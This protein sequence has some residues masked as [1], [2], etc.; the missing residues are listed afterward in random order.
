MDEN[1]ASSEEAAVYFPD[2]NQYRESG[3]GTGSTTTRA[4]TC[5]RF[6]AIIRNDI[7]GGPVHEASGRSFFRSTLKNEGQTPN[8]LRGMHGQHTTLSLTRLGV[9]DWCRPAGCRRQRPMSMAEI[10]GQNKPAPQTRF[11]AWDHHP[12]HRSIIWLDAL[13]TANFPQS[14]DLTTGLG[15]RVLNIKGQ[16]ES[17]LSTL[18]PTPYSGRLN[19]LSG[20]SRRC[21][22]WDHDP[23]LSGCITFVVVTSLQS[24]S[25]LL[26]L[27]SGFLRLCRLLRLHQCKTLAIISSRLHMRCSWCR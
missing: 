4:R 20:V 6:L 22:A 14:R 8:A 25:G 3:K 26:A 5:R 27:C 24:W 11:S 9:R 19:E 23:M 17:R 7:W 10:A 1:N 16:S 21:R 2:Q 12:F 13:Q 15:K 18:C